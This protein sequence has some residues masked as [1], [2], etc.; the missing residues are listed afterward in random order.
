MDDERAA[1]RRDIEGH[2]RDNG[3]DGIPWGLEIA[4]P[5]NSPPVVEIRHLAHPGDKDKTTSRVEMVN[6]EAVRAAALDH[7]RR[8]VR[9]TARARAA[10]TRKEG[11]MPLHM[12]EAHPLLMLFRRLASAG[13]AALDGDIKTVDGAYHKAHMLTVRI[14]RRGFEFCQSDGSS[15]IEFD[16]D[17]PDTVL[18]ALAGRRLV[19]VVALPPSG[20]PKLDAAV[21]RV[22]IAEARRGRDRPTPVL[23]LELEPTPVVEVAPTPPGEDGS[24]KDMEP[25][26]LA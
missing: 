8:V 17:M 18:A 16:G 25:R 2:L 14:D 23:V 26:P 6:R 9:S 4:F 24:W 13:R 20:E 7:G 10:M 21:A 12:L 11:P 3:L 19:D 1:V 15:V 5:P 22:T